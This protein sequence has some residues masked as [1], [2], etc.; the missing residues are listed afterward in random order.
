MG[1]CFGKDDD[2]HSR[3]QEPDERSS[4][5]GNQIGGNAVSRPVTS[6]DFESQPSITRGD[7]QSALNRILHHTANDV[8]D[9]S[10]LDS[11]A[12][13]QREYMDRARHYSTRI[14]ITSGSTFR[15]RKPT[16]PVGTT[17]PQAVLAGEPVSFADI[18]LITDAAASAARALGDV[19]VVHEEDMIV[20]FDI[21]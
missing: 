11:H 9:V 7:E 5:L 6:D 1:C 4:L 12:V 2:E 16:L 3:E 14:A 19:K 10:A 21:P 20:H 18:R 13:E 8:I 15:T 17:V